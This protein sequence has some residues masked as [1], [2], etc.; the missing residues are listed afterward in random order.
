MTIR[1]HRQSGRPSH[2]QAAHRR[3]E[4]RGAMTLAIAS[5]TTGVVLGSAGLSGMALQ[6]ASPGGWSD[7]SDPAQ[8]QAAPAAQS[9]V[10]PTPASVPTSATPAPAT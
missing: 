5:L 3:T 6:F 10:D 8:V 7:T 9:T 4:R 1:S 2:Y